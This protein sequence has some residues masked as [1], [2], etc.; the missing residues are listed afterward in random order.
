MTT[1]SK[2]DR[3]QALADLRS[4][5]RPGDTI[6]VILRRAAR[7][8]MSR[9]ITPLLLITDPGAIEERQRDQLSQAWEA[10]DLMPRAITLGE[11]ELRPYY[12]GYLA[13][14]ILGLS[15]DDQAVRMTGAGMDM[16]FALVHWLA[17]AAFPDG[18]DCIGE[19]CP[20]NDHANA[21]SSHCPICGTPLEREHFES[22][23]ELPPDSGRAAYLGRDFEPGAPLYPKGRFACCSQACADATWHHAEGGYALSHKWL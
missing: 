10:R 21:R 7:S 8:G 5:V 18:F 16:G 14:K 6:Y 4:I 13:S 22:V 3:E 17:S 1:I 20:S 11:R 15:W 9:W 19:K 23:T 12:L 2:T